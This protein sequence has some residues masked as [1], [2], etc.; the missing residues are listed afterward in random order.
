MCLAVPGQLIC[1]LR[2]EVPFCEAEIDFLGVRRICNLSCVP[3][4]EPGQYVIVHAGVA[5]AVV[6]AAAADKWLQDLRSVE[7]EAAWDDGDLL[8]R[9][10]AVPA[11]ADT[12]K[13]PT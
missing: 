4:A 9:S 1:W 10:E 2:R 8:T 3:E 5:I 11:A 13:E 12:Q 7:P 6:D